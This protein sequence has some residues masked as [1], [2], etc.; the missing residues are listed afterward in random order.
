MITTLF[1]KTGKRLSESSIKRFLKKAGLKWKRIRKTTKKSPNPDEFENAKQ[2]IEELST[3]HN[4]G[5]ID[6]W[7]FDETGIWNPVS[8][9]PG[10]QLRQ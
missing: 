1:E 8:L 4:N 5:E 6:L 10:N 3:Q 2:E 7:F 9:M